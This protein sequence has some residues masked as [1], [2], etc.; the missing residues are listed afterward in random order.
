MTLTLDQLRHLCS[1][2]ALQ[3]D[4]AHLI[5]LLPQLETIIHFAGQLEQCEIDTSMQTASTMS[6]THTQTVGASTIEDT[7]FTDA[8]LENVRH[9]IIKQMPVLETSLNKE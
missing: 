8:F 9:T 2:T 3:L 5:K 4:E 1:L 7:S 6:H